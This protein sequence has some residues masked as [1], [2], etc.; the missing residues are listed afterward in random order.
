MDLWTATKLVFRRWAI[1]IPALTL[2]VVVAIVVT[3]RVA[4]TYKAT[5]SVEFLASNNDNKDNPYLGFNASLQTAA[6]LVGSS[7]GSI[8]TR[9]GFATFGLD[10]NYKITAPYDPT[11]AV[12]VPSL[13]LEVNSSNPKI[14]VATLKR[15]VVAVRN[16]LNDRQAAS[17][18]PKASWIQLRETAVDS[19][20]LKQTGS[21]TKVLLL[22]VLLG[23]AVSISLAFFVESLTSDAKRKRAVAAPAGVGD[24]YVPPPPP[25]PE[26]ADSLLLARALETMR[27]ALNVADET[28]QRAVG[29]DA[30]T[31]SPAPAETAALTPGDGEPGTGN[32]NGNGIAK[33]SGNGNG[34]GVANRKPIPTEGIDERPR[35][36]TRPESPGPKPEP[37]A[38]PDG[39]D[40]PS[41]DR[42]F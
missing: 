35:V 24:G 29:D 38:R 18:A 40:R 22:I 36:R 28:A 12:L 30:P 16:D 33:G 41:D 31:P 2:T 21:K 20:A 13:D 9:A 14:A 37:R 19:Q 26:S 42:G 15:L 3:G 27:L 7:V 1:V 10:P 17:G 11:R 25:E 34:N 4:P 5:G 23:F 32:A 6:T 8:G 39:G